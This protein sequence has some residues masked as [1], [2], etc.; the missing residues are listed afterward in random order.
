MDQVHQLV[1]GQSFTFYTS[2]Q[3]TPFN[4]SYNTAA[5]SSYHVVGHDG[6]QTRQL[7]VE[8]LQPQGYMMMMPTHQYQDPYNTSSSPHAP[9]PLSH[10]PPPPSPE[11]YDPLSPPISGSDTSADG[12]YN[13]SGNNS[14][15]S[16]RA[17][18]LVHRHIRYNPTPSPTSSSGRRGV[19]KTRT[20]TRWVPITRILLTLE[21][22]PPGNKG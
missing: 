2:D 21:R 15:S 6:S 14:P 3:E 5:M 19:P 18:S 17:N 10:S 12:L 1:D 4:V 7:S 8:D 16:S 22:K 13:S 9:I 11:L 20:K